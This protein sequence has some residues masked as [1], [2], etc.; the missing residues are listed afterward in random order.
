MTK[1][2]KI[3]VVGSGY[4]GMSLSVLLAQHN[5]V[6]VFDTDIKKVNKINNKSST[7]SDKKINDFLISKTLNLK[8]TSSKSDAYLDSNF[9]VIAT[10][11]DYDE[12][13]GKFDTR[14]V[15]GVVEDVLA[16]NK[17]ALIVIKSTI[18][19]GYTKNLHKKYNT[20]R[21]I[22]SPEFL[23]EGNALNDN[24]YPSSIVIVSFSEESKKFASLL[25]EGAKKE[26][27]NVLH[28]CSN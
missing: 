13:S 23:R 28:T 20:E 16:I 3:T 17:S 1:K 2:T 6:V 19:V 12:E 8:A 9:V 10:P 14:T 18:P 24:L 5:D 15:D 26:N 22:F 21:I 7:I 27:I 4:V 11:T 25:V